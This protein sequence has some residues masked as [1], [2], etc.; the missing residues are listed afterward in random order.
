MKDYIGNVA[1]HFKGKI[2]WWEVLNEA[3]DGGSGIPTNWK[4]VLRKDSPWYIAYENGANKAKG[5][6]GADYIYDAFALARLADPAAVLYYNDFNETEAWEYT[7]MA[8]MAEDLNR[9]WKTDARNVQPGRPLVEGIGL[10]GHYWT[11]D[12]SVA[13]VEAAIVRLVK[14]GVKI[15]ITELDIPAGTYSARSLILKGT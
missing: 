14:A 6:S 7:A 5:E 15:S 2:T 1:G 9:E 4:A 13:D 3:F 8:L 11:G 10:Q 12:L